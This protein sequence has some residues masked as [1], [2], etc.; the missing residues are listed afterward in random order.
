MHTLLVQLLQQ[1]FTQLCYQVDRYHHFSESIISHRNNHVLQQL[2]LI[3]ISY[4]ANNERT[5]ATETV[6]Q[7]CTVTVKVEFTAMSL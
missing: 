5:S 3:I 2:L 4:R 6:F 7:W 1:N